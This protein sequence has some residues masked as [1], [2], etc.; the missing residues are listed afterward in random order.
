VREGDIIDLDVE[1]RSLHLE[2]SDE[3]L[4]RRLVAWRAPEPAMKGGYQQL[5]VD[6]VMPAN[7][8]ADFDFLLGGRGHEV[9]RE[10]H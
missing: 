10:S 5:Y 2:V 1:A 8:G 9:P 6:H 7:T 4:R 3:E